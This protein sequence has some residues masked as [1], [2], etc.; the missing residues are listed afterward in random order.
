MK[1]LD[2]SSADVADVGSGRQGV[3]RARTKGQPRSKA[4][5]DGE[6]PRNDLVADIGTAAAD[7]TTSPV[8]KSAPATRQDGDQ[9]LMVHGGRTKLG[10]PGVARANMY[11]RAGWATPRGHRDVILWG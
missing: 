10:G 11:L 3:D 1:V 8:Q 2:T 9:L 7:A 6:I 4:T 5:L